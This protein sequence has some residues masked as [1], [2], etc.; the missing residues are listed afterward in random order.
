MKNTANTQFCASALAGVILV[1][2]PFFAAAQ[3][4]GTFVFAGNMNAERGFSRA[5]L[6]TNGSVLITGYGPVVPTPGSSGADLYDSATRTFT[7][8]ETPVNWAFHSS[9]LLPDGRVLIAGGYSGGG[10]SV[11]AY[12]FDPSTRSF[13][14]TG[15][16]TRP[17]VGH[18]A[19][20]LNNGK[21]L[22]AGG[23]ATRPPFLPDITAELYDPY[24]GSFTKTGTFADGGPSVASSTLLPDGKVLITGYYSGRAAVYDPATESFSPT[25]NRPEFHQAAT[26]L[27]NGK[28]LL[29]GGTDDNGPDAHA[30][31]YDPHTGSF[32]PETN[33]TIPRVGPSVTL[34]SDGT[35]VVIGGGLQ[36][37]AEVYD[38]D[39]RVF[40]PT[41][42]MLVGRYGHS[43]TLL[44]DGNILIAGGGG[45][46]GCVS[47][48]T[49][50]IYRPAVVRPVAALIS[51]PGET[52]S[53][54]AI[55]H[56]KSHEEVTGD[57]PA[58][59]GEA[60]E[61][62]GSGLFEGSVVPPQVTIGGR[63]AEVLY[64]GSAP[65]LTGVSQVNVRVPAGITAGPSVPV[66]MHYMGRISNEVTLAIR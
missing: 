54:G 22:L 36:N 6:L 19:A 31:T 60:L 1:V 63:L 58:V 29:V 30:E 12:L 35:V 32:T 39:A 48:V 33:L 59:S 38:P 46:A 18:T 25:R 23:E 40:T 49:A 27:P 47:A 61:I 57:H 56:A 10:S 66:R 65:R 26:L 52:G 51:M 37:T 16:M 8:I 7:P 42:E 45:C 5:T 4:A 34:L 43:A 14:L 41:A 15:D 17:R 28:V 3:P 24:S 13:S 21:V 44:P 53:R 64:Y 11:R 2:C 9:T 55:L 20:L 62:Y 50:D